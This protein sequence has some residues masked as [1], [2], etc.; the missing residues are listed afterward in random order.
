MRNRYGRQ[1]EGLVDRKPELARL[2]QLADFG[3]CVERVAVAEAVTEVLERDGGSAV[4]IVQPGVAVA[5]RPDCW[6]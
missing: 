4:N 2:D 6:C 3:Q 1:R 5:S